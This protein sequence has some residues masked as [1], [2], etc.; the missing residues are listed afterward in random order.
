MI[1]CNKNEVVN[2]IVHESTYRCLSTKRYHS[3]EFFNSP[4]NDFWDSCKR[5]FDA[6]LDLVLSSRI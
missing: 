5:A 3:E 4:L 1:A 6:L 2:S